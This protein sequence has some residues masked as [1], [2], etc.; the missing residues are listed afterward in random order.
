[1]A[2]CADILHSKPGMWRISRCLKCGLVATLPRIDK[3]ELSDF[4]PQNYAPYN[5]SGRLKDGK[6]TGFFRNLVMA[7]YRF[8][9]GDPDFVLQ[10]FGGGKLFEIG[11]GSGMLIKRMRMIGWKCDGID[12]SQHAVNQAKQNNPDSNISKSDLESYHSNEKYDL[13]ILA[14]VLEHFHDPIIALEICKSLLNDAGKIYIAVPN[15]NSWDAKVFGRYWIGLDVP[16]HTTHFSDASL[17]EILSKF[18]FEIEWSRPA[19]FATSISESLI[20]MLPKTL[21]SIMQNSI[22]SKILYFI[23]I[24]PASLTYLFGNKPIIEVLAQRK[25]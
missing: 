20:L 4:Y 9:F 8:R 11:C 15:I 17:F 13:I 6:F 10:P 22:A 12:F 14:H 1:M 3:S 7:V 21:R 25:Y 5:F 19:M 18:G 2:N 24:F 16:R 23:C